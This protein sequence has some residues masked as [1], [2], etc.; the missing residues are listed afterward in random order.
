M[1]IEQVVGDEETTRLMVRREGDGP[2]VARPG[3]VILALPEDNLLHLPPFEHLAELRPDRLR[4]FGHEQKALMAR[5]GIG[6]LHVGL[7]DIVEIRLPV[8]SL[9]RPGQHDA[10]LWFPFGGNVKI[11]LLIFVHVVS[12]LFIRHKISINLRKYKTLQPFLFLLCSIK[13]LSAISVTTFDIYQNGVIDICQ[14][15]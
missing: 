7:L 11:A 9:M 15:L 13:A 10:A 5:Y 4:V 1:E 12:G 3:V 6:E 2:E 8:G 14:P